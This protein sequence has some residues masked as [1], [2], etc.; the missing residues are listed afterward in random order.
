MKTEKGLTQSDSKSISIGL[1]FAMGYNG[2]FQKAIRYDENMVSV[3][4]ST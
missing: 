1:W 2:M 3:K 4:H